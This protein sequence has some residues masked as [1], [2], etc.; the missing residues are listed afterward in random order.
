MGAKWWYNSVHDPDTNEG[1]V[2]TFESIGD[3][4]IS[5]IVCRKIIMKPFY[6]YLFYS[7]TLFMYEDSGRVFKYYP[8]LD[9]FLTLYD[10]NLSPGN[11]YTVYCDNSEG[12]IVDSL[13]I[14]ITS[15]EN[16]VVNGNNLRKQK[17]S[18]FFSGY[19]LGNEIIERIGSTYF[20]IPYYDLTEIP[21]GPL[22][23]YEDNVIGHYE[24]GY[25]E[26]CD[27]I[28]NENEIEN[29]ETIFLRPTITGNILQIVNK[30]SLIIA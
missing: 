11:T 18:F 7:D 2:T 19:T 22:R 26:Y 3:T 17:F 15:S 14:T 24:T 1:V 5:G 21:F 12:Y 25:A 28:L 6:T 13:L 27:I 10:F 8:A 29:N 9:T 20:L 30:S 23:C 16:I 4:T